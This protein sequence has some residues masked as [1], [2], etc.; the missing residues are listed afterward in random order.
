MGRPKEVQDAETKTFRLPASLIKQLEA[1]GAMRQMKVSDVIREILERNIR[2]FFDESL[3][4]EEERLQMAIAAL[5]EDPV[6]LDRF[7]RYKDEGECPVPAEVMRNA[8]RLALLSTAIDAY[9]AKQSKRDKMKE[10]FLPGKERSHDLLSKLASAVKESLGR[11]LR[12]LAIIVDTGD[13][14]LDKNGEGIMVFTV[15]PKVARL[16][17]GGR[18]EIPGVRQLTRLLEGGSLKE[19][20]SAEQGQRVYHWSR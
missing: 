13:L 1:A 7:D 20:P 6:L 12:H 15:S 8:K 19:V 16:L 18:L 9:K 2:A 3:K 5:K 11:L 14:T 17:D 4:I 10:L